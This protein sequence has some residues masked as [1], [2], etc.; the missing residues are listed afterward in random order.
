MM[1]GVIGVMEKYEALEMMI[2]VLDAE[3]VIITSDTG[4]GV[5]HTDPI[6]IP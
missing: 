3:D 4:N 2:V 1:K 6:P 5:I